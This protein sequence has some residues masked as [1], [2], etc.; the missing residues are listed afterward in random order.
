MLPDELGLP[1]THLFELLGEA[2][3]VEVLGAEGGRHGAGLQV[4]GALVGDGASSVSD[5]GEGHV[6]VVAIPVSRRAAEAQ[7]MAG[8]FLAPI[9]PGADAVPPIGPAFDGHLGFIGFSRAGVQDN[10]AGHAAAAEGATSSADHLDA[11]DVFRVDGQVEQVVGRVW[12]TPTDAV[13][14]EGDLFEGS[15]P[16]AEVSLNTPRAALAGIDAGHGLEQPIQGGLGGPGQHFRVQRHE[17]A[18]GGGLR[19]RERGL[20]HRFGYGQGVLAKGG[21]ERSKQ[22]QGEGS[23]G[24]HAGQL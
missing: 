18:G 3:R 12:G 16:D 20:D 8:L 14:P 10:A 1:E 9:V 24:R 13:H 17:V 19:F 22:K 11:L 6:G 2:G 7:S 21:E 5:P 15:T 4:K 23:P